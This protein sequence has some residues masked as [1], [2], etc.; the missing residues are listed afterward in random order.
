MALDVA[1][2]KA[3]TSVAGTSGFESRPAAVWRD[4]AQEAGAS[5]SSDAYGNVFA[6][7][8]PGGRPRVMLAGHI[9]EIGLLVN[10]I[11]D[12]G[13]LY[14]RPVGGW[15]PMQLVGQRVRVLGYGGDIVGVIGK[16]AIHLMSAE[17]RRKV[18]SMEDLWIDIG[19]TSAE[20]AGS[21]V[22]AGDSAVIEQTFVEL[23]NGRV[24][25]RA[26]DDRIGAYVALEAARRAAG[27]AE[28]IAVATVQEEI[29]GV[30]ARAA[31]FALEPDVAIAIDVTHA[32]DTPGLEKKLHGDVPLAG[33]PSLSAGSYVHRSVMERLR[34]TAEREG[35]AV[36]MGV[37]P[38][39]TGT[40]ADNIAPSRAGTPSAVVSIP[41][42]Y[43]HSP[44]EVVDLADVE[45][46]IELLAAFIAGLD[47]DTRFLHD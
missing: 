11:D 5:L 4:R 20:E 42:R 15:D 37:S 34:S 38:R 17:D 18:P 7:F 24:A 14:V 23:L 2:L 32:T 43:M 27:N 39:S 19:A 44:N 3:L 12:K 28:V 9:D 22:R 10:Y 40:D 30:G 47:A 21:W 1:F 31:A 25:S 26:I 29:G 13:F 46:T 45:R 16:K 8:R 41:N 36:S 35:I 6:A 33:G